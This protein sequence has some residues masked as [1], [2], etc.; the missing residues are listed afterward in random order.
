VPPGWG[1]ERGQRFTD[2]GGYAHLIQAA[3]QWVMYREGKADWEG[4]GVP[5]VK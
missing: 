5:A 1:E 2:A 3:A 4:H